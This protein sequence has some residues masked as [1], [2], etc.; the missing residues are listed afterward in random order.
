MQ[1]DTLL[2]RKV[3]SIACGDAHSVALV[4]GMGSYDE[5]IVNR[6]GVEY[7]CDVMAWGDNN[8][9]Q[10][11]G[12]ITVDKYPVPVVLPQFVGKKILHVS[13]YR[14]K[15]CAVEQGG[16]IYEW[17][18]AEDSC[19]I[20]VV[21]KVDEALEMH[22][23]TGFSIVR[24]IDKVFFWGELKGKSRNIMN[25]RKPFLIS[26][27]TDVKAVS[28]GADHVLMSDTSDMVVSE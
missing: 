15:S 25:E 2:N 26:G 8:L 13:C 10:V 22:Y 24:T 19:N 18:G 23:G 5:K 20:K 9:G 3:L 12:D 16:N 4:V 21:Q 14:S 11:S 6:D 1:I 7:L 17:G 28:V 27:D